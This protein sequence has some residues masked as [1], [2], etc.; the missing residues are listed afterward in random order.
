MTIKKNFVSSLIIGGAGAVGNLFVQNLR[1]T[2]PNLK[3]SVLDLIKPK[4]PIPNVRYESNLDSYIEAFK[5]FDLVILALPEVAALAILPDIKKWLKSDALVVDTLSVKSN[6]CSKVKTLS[7]DGEYLSINPM[8][9]PNIGFSQQT[10][11]VVPVQTGHRTAN[12]LQL[13]SNWG[14]TVKMLTVDEHDLATAQLQSL[15]HATIM[16]FGLALIKGGYDINQLISMASPP[17]KTMLSLLAR[18]LSGSPDV[19]RDIQ[20]NNPH[21]SDVR[22]NLVDSIKTIDDMITQGSPSDFADLFDKFEVLLSEQREM[23]TEQCKVVFK[24]LS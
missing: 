9:A 6:I 5:E 21:A 23:L 8:F 17:H 16:A 13:L 7:L 19:Y 11:L 15:T 24:S 1:E 14:A 4:Q 18:I 12:F 2:F 20:L 3:I 10:V 22:H